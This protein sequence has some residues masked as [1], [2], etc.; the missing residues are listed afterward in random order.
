VPLPLYQHAL[1]AHAGRT[2]YIIPAISLA[3]GIRAG[4]RS[5]ANALH[6][7]GRCPIKKFLKLVSALAL[8]RA[9]TRDSYYWRIVRAM[10]NESATTV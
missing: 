6:Y 8:L 9:R 1:R 5:A 3:C 2:S 10:L 7:S 4:T